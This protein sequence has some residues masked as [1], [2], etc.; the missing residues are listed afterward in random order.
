V[1]DDDSRVMVEKLLRGTIE[2]PSQH[3]AG[4]PKLLD[5]IA[6]HGLARNPEQR[7][8]TAREMALALERFG[9]M[10]RPTEV[11]EWVER[12]AT[13]GLAERT[14]K[15]KELEMSSAFRIVPTSQALVPP[16]EV[17]VEWNGEPESDS[18]LPT[19]VLGESRSS[20]P[21][22]HAVSIVPMPPVAAGITGAPLV[23]P[24]PRPFF[25][26][27]AY[28]LLGASI[29]LAIFTLRREPESPGDIAAANVPAVAHAAA[30]G[31]AMVPGSPAPPLGSGKP[32]DAGPARR[33]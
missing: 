18:M 15:L 6:L 17:E 33:R 19:R 3:S 10:A 8:A 31:G 30:L 9:D 13:E 27:G 2:A 21:S 4:V 25:V 1:R 22:P 23:P 20:M 26:F 28:A 29:A 24:A 11:A 16:G 32:P 5:A 14:R 12:L 7:F